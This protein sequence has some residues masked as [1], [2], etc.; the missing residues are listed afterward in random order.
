MRLWF[1]LPDDAKAAVANT[2]P[3]VVVWT[4]GCYDWGKDTLGTSNNARLLKKK[5]RWSA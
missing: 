3:T 5:D 4:L 1:L 2:L